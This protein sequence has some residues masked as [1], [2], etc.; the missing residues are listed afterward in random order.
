MINGM[1]PVLGSKQT[2]QYKTVQ[3]IKAEGQ[4]YFQLKEIPPDQCLQFKRK[5]KP[6]VA[7][8]QIPEAGVERISR[9]AE[10][11]HVVK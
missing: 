8:I 11:G 3:I 4:T 6:S 9:E 7:F 5:K 10:R 1:F 2:G